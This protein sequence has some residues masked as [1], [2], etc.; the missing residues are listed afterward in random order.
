MYII[1]LDRWVHQTSNR[2]GRDRVPR[3]RWLRISIGTYCL[4]EEECGA[5]DKEDCEK[6][7]CWKTEISIVHPMRY[8]LCSMRFLSMI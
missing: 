8:P 3:G 2:R 6:F 4:Y 5:Y 1:I 7:V